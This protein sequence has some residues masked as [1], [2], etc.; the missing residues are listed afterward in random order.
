M[1]GANSAVVRRFVE[2]YQSRHRVEVAEELLGADFVDRSPFDPLPP[3]RSGVRAMF[4]VLFEAFPDLRAETRDQVEEDDKVVTR[5]TFRGTHQAEFMGVPVTGR[6]VAWDVIDILRVRE[7][8]MAKHWDVV[9]TL[10]LVQQLGA[11][12]ETT[13]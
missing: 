6:S 10:G 13:G 2:E 1:P 8:Q 5:K 3:D 12:S 9:E 7:G 11:I 4:A